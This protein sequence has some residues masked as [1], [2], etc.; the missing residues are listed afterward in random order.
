M[1]SIPLIDASCMCEGNGGIWIVHGSLPLL[2][3]FDY[4]IERITLCK[5]IPVST[6]NTILPFSA[7]VKDDKRI[8]LIAGSQNKTLLYNIYEDKFTEIEM[9]DS[10]ENAFYRVLKKD[11]ELYVIPFRHDKVKKVNMDTLAVTD[12]DNWK[13]LYEDST[14]YIN[15]T[16]CITDN[17]NFLAPV[18]TTNTCLFYDVQK[19]IWKKI[20][21]QEKSVDCTA[22]AHYKNKIYIFDRNDNTIKRIDMSGN[23][24]MCKTV[25][26]REVT[27]HI[28]AGKLVLDAVYTKDIIIFDTNL[29]EI[30]RF[31]KITYKSDNSLDGIFLSWYNNNGKY[32]VI[33]RSNK[34]V[35]ID[36]KLKVKKYD[37]WIDSKLIDDII[38]DLFVLKKQ[39]VII[40]NTWMGLESYMQY[41]V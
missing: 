21:I 6:P 3:F 31:Q 27:L 15:N 12:G 9:D 20:E 36:E 39:N 37:L 17:G 8:F 14:L 38:S 25:D 23:V 34:L 32:F 33:T 19:E 22:V 2:F 26:I 10:Y 11:R 24:E 40:E 18:P 1:N 28:I 29:K 4:H 13:K 7:I 5:I 30:E 35:V 16:G 41:L